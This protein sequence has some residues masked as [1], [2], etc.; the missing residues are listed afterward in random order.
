MAGDYY[1][2]L[3]LARPGN[4][5]LA[6]GG[7]AEDRPGEGPLALC[8]GDVAGKGMTAALLMSSLQAAVR[9]VADATTSPARVCEQVRRVLTPSLA[10]GRFVT[11]FYAVLDPAIG[12]LAYTNAGHVPPVLVRADGRVER[13]EAGG[14][15]L[16]RLLAGTP[17]RDEVTHLVPGDR[18]VLVTDGV[19]EAQ[20]GSGE[21]FGEERL[22]ELLRAHRHLAA[23]ALEELLV[24]TLRAYTVGDPGDDLTLLILAAD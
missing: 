13:L 3:P 20:D 17:F 12:R 1:D 23:G 22:L 15:A 9:A 21:L 11:F 4:G 7:S 5:A 10:G 2:V 24:S 14:G 8:I 16:A 6:E 19:T 18:L